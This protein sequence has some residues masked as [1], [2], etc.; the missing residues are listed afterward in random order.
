MGEVLQSKTP[1]RYQAKGFQ[2]GV[3]AINKACRR[4][5]EKQSGCR[6]TRLC[7]HPFFAGARSS[8]IVSLVHRFCQRTI[9]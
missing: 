1:W 5:D 7:P 3:F 6:V 4:D 2:R 9:V 8:S